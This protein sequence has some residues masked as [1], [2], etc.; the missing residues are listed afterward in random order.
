MKILYKSIIIAGLFSA[1]V[2]LVQNRLFKKKQGSLV[3]TVMAP[4]ELFKGKFLVQAEFDTS[5][6]NIRSVAD[7]LIDRMAEVGLSYEIKPVSKIEIQLNLSEIVDTIFIKNMITRVGKI[8]FREVV[9][10]EELSLCFDE[11][12]SLYTELYPEKEEPVVPLNDSIPKDI[13]E[14]MTGMK[15]D[16]KTPKGFFKHFNPETY[17]PAALGK[18]AESDTAF[19][20]QF[21]LHP[22][23]KN[24]TP[25]NLSFVYGNNDFK[26]FD[27]RI[28]KDTIFNLYA[29]RTYGVLEKDVLQNKY[30]EYASCEFDEQGRP[31][32]SFQFNDYG[33]QKWKYLT[34]ANIEKYIAIIFDDMVASAPKV[35]SE[36]STGNSTITGG[37]SGTEC[38]LFASMLNT[39]I[40]VKRLN[41]VSSEIQPLLSKK[42]IP[43]VIKWGC[44]FL[45][46]FFATFFTLKELNINK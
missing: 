32:V 16:D 23:V 10:I 18:V 36:I 9:P 29:V 7:V 43:N 31:E 1:A 12:E 4:P 6:S 22:Q 21:L 45:I 19:I 35:L 40:P 39:D 15:E 24:K 2:F 20:R 42:S 13:R 17:D 14:L 25:A 38:R 5:E 26:I 37:F 33:T 27:S 46:L 41:L 30:I 11:A 8:E 28:R 34:S 44:I 3:D